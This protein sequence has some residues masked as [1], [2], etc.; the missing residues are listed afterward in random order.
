MVINGGAGGGAGGLKVI[1][2]GT[3]KNGKLLLPAPAK[4]V[5]ITF[6]IYCCFA[7]PTGQEM[8]MLS[9]NSIIARCIFHTDGITLNFTP[10]E[11]G[12]IFSFIYKALG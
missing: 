1:A 4:I 9:S 10:E 6:S 12:T 3:I 11:S 2:E 7:F 8:R 5:F